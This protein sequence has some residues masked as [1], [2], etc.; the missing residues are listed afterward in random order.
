VAP[1]IC[2]GSLDL[3]LAQ[4]VRRRSGSHAVAGLV[5]PHVW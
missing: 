1:G 5:A 2:Y 4:P 3:K